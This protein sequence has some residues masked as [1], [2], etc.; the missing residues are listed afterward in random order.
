MKASILIPCYNEEQ[1]IEA[2]LTRLADF[3]SKNSDY[4]I[5]VEEDGS[6][7]STPRI[8]DK[9]AESYA[10]IS[11]VHGSARLRKGGGL[12][13]GARHSTGG[14]ILTTDADL[15]V[16]P[17]EFPRLVREIE[18]GYDIV[19]ASRRHGDAKLDRQAPV[20]RRLS[21]LI[22][23]LLVNALFG[24]GI[25]DTQSGTKAFRREVFFK[26]EPRISM[27]YAMDVEML[28][29]AKKCN[30]RVREIGVHYVHGDFSRFSLVKNGSKMLKDVLIIW[31][32][33]VAGRM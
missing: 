26:I 25:R 7:D 11:S 18:N 20:M 6:T 24:F 14:I 27:D 21:S 23:N 1:R 17:E 30:F 31:L 3:A 32:S 15:A 2:A 4:E 10:F 28:A 8:I 33:Y 16:P 5:V 13:L 22:F 19:I 12:K 29:R 9:F